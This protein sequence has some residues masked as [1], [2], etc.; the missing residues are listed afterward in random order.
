MYQD[1]LNDSNDQRYSDSIR[2]GIH[3]TGRVT[4]RMALEMELIKKK[5]TEFVYL[6]KDKK[7]VEQLDEE[8]PK[9]LEKEALALFLKTTEEYGLKHDYLMFL[10]LSYT[11]LRVGELVALK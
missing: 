6:K 4:F 2:E 11:R 9:H 1:A 8:I 3:G 5:P 10:I 7:T